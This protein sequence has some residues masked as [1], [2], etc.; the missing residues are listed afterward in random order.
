MPKNTSS[1]T[2]TEERI[3]RLLYQTKVSLTIYEIAKQI[4]I[5]YPTAKKYVTKL[6]TRGAIEEDNA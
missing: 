1:F 2:P 5:S 6:T 4:S 3:M